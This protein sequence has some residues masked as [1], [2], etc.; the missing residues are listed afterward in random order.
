MR[1]GSSP[2]ILAPAG[3][4]ESADAA[5]CCG[6]DAVYFG[7]T[8]F[9]ARA[10]ADNFSD[11]DIKKLAA[12]CH[13]RGVAVHRALN[14]VVFDSEMTDFI[15]TAVSSA[16]A[17]V[18]AFIVQD[19]GCAA[20]LKKILPGM[21]LHASTQMTVHTPKGALEARDM[22]FSRV[23]PARELNA[24]QIKAICDTGIETEIFVHGALCMC[25]SGQCYMSALIGSRS[26]NR[27]RCA[28]ACRLPFDGTA[29][30]RKDRYDLSL[31]DLSYI[32]DIPMLTELGVSSLKIEGRMKRPE[33]VAAAVTACRDVLDGRE[34][35]IESLKAVFSRSGFTDGYLSGKT[36]SAMF[37]FRRKDDVTAAASVLPKLKKLYTS[38]KPRY[39]LD[40]H[41]ELHLGALSSLTAVCGGITVSVSGSAPEKAVNRPTDE[42]FVSKQLS[43][44]G[45]TVFY[46]GNITV[47]LDEDIAV[48]SAVLNELRRS[49]AEKIVS[50]VTASNTPVYEIAE[51]DPKENNIP[52]C[53]TEGKT[54]RIHISSAS[55]LKTALKYGEYAVMPVSECIKI[56]ND[57][58]ISRIIAAPPRFISDEEKL[59]T[60]LLDLRGHGFTKLYCG[61]IAHIRAGREAG[62][63]LSG[64]YGLNITNSHSAAVMKELGLSDV[65]LSFEMT[66]G[67]IAAVRS[68]LPC[69]LIVY[70][71]LPLMAV[72]N[73]PVRY[74]SG[75]AACK[76]RITDRTGRSFPVRCSKNKDHAEIFNC[77]T[78]FICDKTDKMKNIRFLD[79]L[80]ADLSPEETEKALRGCFGGKKPSSGIT[81]GLY[82]RGVCPKKS[83]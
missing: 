35:D 22:G 37:G 17:G 1:R 26:A 52:R 63:E 64:G 8:D 14:T 71:R 65:T 56:G 50:A 53:E 75:C 66:F 60:D 41:A 59:F 28:Q 23:V 76:G 5:C 15:N 16:K 82:Y 61:N 51:Y 4:F 39:P 48:P 40:M 38:E 43:K 3:N 54:A 29:S 62:F 36:G 42:A 68:P 69:A 58:D 80:T 34:P 30:G 45:G 55:Q 67:Q 83:Q 11:D 2:E 79:Y 20:L 46:P 77:D 10:G 73:C 44:L 7:G 32:N 81:G 25:L 18:D 74:A 19:P 70:G 72:K 47:S 49:A 13:L 31:K 21:P 57:H 9:S 24:A 27:G 33:Y 6:A 12:H 78:L